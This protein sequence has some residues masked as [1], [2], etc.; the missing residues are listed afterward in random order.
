[1]ELAHARE[2]ALRIRDL[3]DE[4]NQSVRGRTWTREEYMLSFVGTW[5]IWPSW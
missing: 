5:A 1:M 2:R 4:L 3:Y